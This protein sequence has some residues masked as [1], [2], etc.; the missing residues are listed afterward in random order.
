MDRAVHGRRR[1]RNFGL[2]FVTMSNYHSATRVSSCHPILVAMSPVTN[3][4]LSYLNFQALIQTGILGSLYKG[5]GMKYVKRLS[6]EALCQPLASDF[7]EK[8]DITLAMDHLAEEGLIAL[9]DDGSFSRDFDLGEPLESS[10]LT[11]S[12][13]SYVRIQL[14]TKNS[15]LS[16]FIQGGEDWLFQRLEDAAADLNALDPI[17]FA[18]DKEVVL[19]DD[20]Q[21]RIKALEKVDDLIRLLRSSNAFASAGGRGGQDALLQLETGRKLLQAG[22]VSV[23]KIEAGFYGAIGFIATKFAETPIAEAA[24]L[25]WSAIKALISHLI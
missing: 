25:A 9:H 4:E 8:E 7:V 18:S 2:C 17:K 20:D 19:H 3:F 10:I 24:Q 12:G 6:L 15:L 11:P 16:E 5:A 22:R 21:L 23:S 1:G 13:E 14:R